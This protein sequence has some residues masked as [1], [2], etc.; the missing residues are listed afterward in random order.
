MGM[1]ED[2]RK[3]V[4]GAMVWTRKLDVPVERVWEAVSTKEGLS[5]WWMAGSPNDIDLR[6]G[7]VFQHHWRSTVTDLK[8]CEYID[9]ESEPGFGH[10]RFELKADGDGTVF[11]FLDIMKEENSRPDPGSYAGPAGGWHSMI[12]ALEMHLTGKKFELGAARD[13]AGRPR[14][15]SYEDELIKFYAGYLSDYFIW[16][17][18]M[19][20]KREAGKQA[21]G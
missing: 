4:D 11:S 20:A 5:K 13:A 15:G 19:K 8:E 9:F 7:G 6:P 14:P 17:E 10:M 21:D 3:F 12:D 2:A 1:E 16:L 18:L